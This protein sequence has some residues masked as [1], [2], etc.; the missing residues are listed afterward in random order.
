MA[1]DKTGE[2]KRLIR[3]ALG[4]DAFQGNAR[5]LTGPLL[6][7]AVA[8]L[9][10]ARHIPVVLVSVGPAEAASLADFAAV[11]KRSG[12]SK[13]ETNWFSFKGVKR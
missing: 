11:W 9:F 12:D 5:H 7:T 13:H 2:L 1:I 10:R 3:D 8:A 6:S 4:G